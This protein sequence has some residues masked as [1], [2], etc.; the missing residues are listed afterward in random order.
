MAKLAIG[1][2]RANDKLFEKF[3]PFILEG[4]RDKRRYVVKAV[5]WALRQI[6]KRNKYLCVKILELSKQIEKIGTKNAK[7]IAKETINEL[8]SKYKY[9][10]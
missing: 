6:G 3:F 5:S 7:R 2:K 9:L 8:L 10:K 1:D 4:A